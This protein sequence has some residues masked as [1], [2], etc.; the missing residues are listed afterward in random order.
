MRQRL[1]QS[2]LMAALLITALLMVVALGLVAANL[3]GITQ[4]LAN[5]YLLP[6]N[7]QISALNVN[8][9]GVLNGHVAQLD[10]QVNDSHIAISD[11]Q[12]TFNDAVTWTHFS[13]ENIDTLAI[14]HIEVL[15]SPTLFSSNPNTELAPTTS[16]ALSLDMVAIPK[17][18]IGQTQLSVQQIPSEQL[19]LSL[20]YL[21][22]DN[23]GRVTSQLSHHDKLLFGLDAQLSDESWQF[24]TRLSLDTLQAFMAQWVASAPA[25]QQETPPLRQ[26][27][28]LKHQLATQHI[29]ISGQLISS[30][31]LDI[32]KARIDSSHQLEPFSLT[33]NGLTG[34]VFNS[35]LQLVPKALPIEGGADSASVSTP[36]N[37]LPSNSIAFE[38]T[39]PVSDLSVSLAP[40]Q[41]EL[42]ISPLQRQAFYSGA[43][44]HAPLLNTL[45]RLLSTTALS[46]S[47][48]ADNNSADNHR[49]PSPPDQDA[50]H[51]Q[52]SLRTLLGELTGQ[53]L[54]LMLQLASPLNYQI[55]SQQLSIEHLQAELLLGNLQLNTE[56]K[57]LKSV[58]KIDETSVTTDWQLTLAHPS[59]LCVGFST[60]QENAAPIAP[61]DTR[62]DSQLRADNIAL[63]ATGS[64]NATYPT[65]LS[66]GAA[67]SSFALTVLPEAQLII[68]GPY[69][70]HQSL[71]VASTQFTLALTEPLSFNTADEVKL[72][73]GHIDIS[74]SGNQFTFV[75]AGEHYQL[76]SHRTE[77]QLS[78][79]QFNKLANGASQWL[80][81][82]LSISTLNPQL[83]QL[84]NLVA[85]L[86]AQTLTSAELVFNSKETLH[87][88]LDAEL[89][90]KN[91][92]KLT[93]QLY[94]PPLMLQ[95]N[96][97]QLT[98]R[99]ISDEQHTIA[100][101][102]NIG[103][104]RLDV[105]A[106]DMGYIASLTE[107]SSSAVNNKPVANTSAQSNLSAPSHSLAALVLNAPWHNQLEL[108]LENISVNQQYY[109]L[110]KRRQRNLFAITQLGMTQQLDWQ[111]SASQYR[112]STAEQWTAGQL[113]MRSQ[114]QLTLAK[115][116]DKV[117][118]QG[119]FALNS[120][121]QQLINQLSS[122][123]ALNMPLT[124]IGDIQLASH[125]QLSWQPDELHFSMQ[126]TP[127]I[128]ISE[129]SINLL[130]FEQFNLDG[131][132]YFSASAIKHSPSKRSINC[133]DLSLQTQAFNPGVVLNNINASTQLNWS[134]QSASSQETKEALLQTADI[135]IN[136]SADTLGGHL[137]LPKFSLDLHQPSE[138]YLVLQ[139]LDLAQL[140]TIQPQ[141][142]IYADG[143]FDGVLPMQI[144]DGK[145]SVT[146]GKLA[147]R[148]PGGLI[149]VGNNPAV[150]QMRS[151]QPYLDFAFS[152]L[153]EL[154][155]SE[156]SSRFDMAA[157]GDAVLHVNVK[158][159]AKD[160][161]RPIHLNYAQEENMLQLLKSL[162]IG[163]RL[164]QDI[165]Q[166]MAQ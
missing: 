152:A 84:S 50:L 108:S 109:Q 159:K 40:S 122:S 101:T 69:Y 11:L 43:T 153:E 100:T 7:T 118:L 27:I 75:Q 29:D 93:T 113:S 115:Q 141:Q 58:N 6:A 32:A 86:P 148:A 131:K 83:T 97:T 46:E 158:G 15:L 51:S 94:L 60:Q 2:R 128:Q 73:F 78:G 114:H 66:A 19:S 160:I 67:T 140:L 77:L 76:A 9:D 25:Q 164:Q 87:I 3:S 26:F 54:Y 112:L 130:P 30:T 154:H 12:L 80:L 150:M 62:I 129:G 5:R 155:Y 64:A 134:S 23:Q 20:D 162:Q 63:S 135:N 111:A 31:R 35:P 121:L 4:S 49:Q 57:H 17:I 79:G 71:D 61:C 124:T 22:I 116:P 92:G 106:I 161:E 10:L 59:T 1:S 41:L 81:R 157:N 133:N 85:A 14:R 90:N 110:K 24:D 163:D 166:S 151:S 68:D 34:T 55:N 18:A 47:N 56:L 146:G 142:G 98:H 139:A 132:C 89:N 138:A 105:G 13:L 74:N 104:A 52:Q 125:H 88:N 91:T 136:A 37:S 82:P 156:L 36:S 95:L 45:D 72:Q 99:Q 70:R 44:T 16:P 65:A 102:T 165:E 137:L 147:A 120:D 38:I 127:K 8:L 28:A 107:E 145:V 21:N 126:L 143:I 39:G 117:A 53:P 33:L 123:F 149:K 96:G 48:V 119:E 103:V 144:V 42:A